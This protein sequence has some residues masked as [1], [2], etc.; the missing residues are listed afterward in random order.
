MASGVGNRSDSK[1]FV[2]RGWARISG[3]RKKN[4]F[5]NP[6]IPEDEPIEVAEV[7]H[8]DIAIDIQP[9]DVVS[10]QKGRFNRGMD[11]LRR[12]L[13]ESFRRKPKSRS[14]DS[15]P[16]EL[17]VPPS[18]SATTGANS[19]EK[20]PAWHIVED[21]VR[22][23][24][25]HFDVKYLGAIEVFE[26]RG[27]DV[28]ENAMKVMRTQRRRVIKGVLYVSGDGLRV[29]DN[30]DNHGL[31]VD[32]TIEKV[33]FCSPDRNHPK[34]FAYICRD[35]T[36]RRW[37]CH[38][39]HATRESGERLSHAVG[40]AFAICLEKKRKREAV[41][42]DQ[43]AAKENTTESGAATNG[44]FANCRNNKAYSSF[45]RQLTISERLQDPQSAIVNETPPSASSSL[46]EDQVLPRPQGNRSLFERQGSFKAPEPASSASSFRRQFSLR[47]D[48]QRKPVYDG[49]SQL[50]NEPIIEGEELW[51]ES[52]L[53]S[54][55]STLP[56]SSSFQSTFTSAPNQ[57]PKVITNSPHAL[58]AFQNDGWQGTPVK[59][60]YP[61]AAASSTNG[62]SSNDALIDWNSKPKLVK[63]VKADDWLEQ[64]LR[65]T[66]LSS[67]T[68]TGSLPVCTEKRS[69]MTS[70][71]PPNHPPPPLPPT[72]D[73]LAA[74]LGSSPPSVAD[75]FSKG[76]Q[77]LRNSVEIS[78]SEDLN[79]S[80]LAKIGDS[81]NSI[82]YSLLNE[83]ANNS[84]TSTA[85][86]LT[87]DC[88]SNGATD[89]FG[90][91]I[92]N[93][94]SPQST[95]T[96]SSQFCNGVVRSTNSA[97]AAPSDDPF[98]VEWST[99][100]INSA[101]SKSTNPFANTLTAAR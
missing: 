45:N 59:R 37:M 96:T 72:A 93:P 10:P 84:T 78:F 30:E 65:N 73:K 94:A 39:F 66:S 1:S 51:P 70:G 43:G 98:D 60:P 35:G 48:C 44:G 25:C 58:S 27:M 29:V 57:S 92:F 3:R 36:T 9:M 16:N 81:T 19:S 5:P 22:A 12:S 11:R 18:T 38:G 49:L 97:S 74:A 87:A 79:N 68:A 24:R 80:T 85:I 61:A 40:C 32:Q 75:P 31:I 47:S 7:A 17:T 62:P 100:A 71:P 33:S 46:F 26:S 2:A 55:F 52:S 76:Y 63:E 56:T 13:R 15:A 99:L 89:L 23:G 77:R 91:P 42:F 90:Q 41:S 67:S 101:A 6:A 54:Q 50:C 88:N 69:M 28:C 34:G 14:T 64:M 83:S 53:I 95:P 8:E 4:R 86:D 20:N 82:A 21:E